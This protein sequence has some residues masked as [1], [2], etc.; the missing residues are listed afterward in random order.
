MG[1]L[2]GVDLLILEFVLCFPNLIPVEMS[3]RFRIFLFL[4]SVSAG[5][6]GSLAS[7]PGSRCP[8]FFFAAASP[9]FGALVN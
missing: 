2:S 1:S 5:F 9:S 8:F 7:P 4:K 3:A 6:I